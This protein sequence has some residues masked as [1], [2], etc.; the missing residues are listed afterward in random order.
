MSAPADLDEL[1]RRVD[2][3][4]ADGDSRAALAAALLRAGEREAAAE[5]WYLAACSAR[6]DLP[7]LHERLRRVLE[8]EPAYPLVFTAPPLAHP[9][10]REPWARLLVVIPESRVRSPIA[11]LLAERGYEVVETPTAGSARAAIRERAFDLVLTAPQT[12]DGDAL[13]VAATARKANPKTAIVLL[14]C[15]AKHERIDD[16]LKLQPLVDE[17]LDRPLAAERLTD[18]VKAALWRHRHATQVELGPAAAPASSPPSLLTAWPRAVLLVIAGYAVIF[19]AD[20][21]LRTLARARQSESGMAAGLSGPATAPLPDELD[22]A[23][24]RS[25]WVKLTSQTGGATATLSVT[26]LSPE[27]VAARTYRSARSG[28]PRRAPLPDEVRSAVERFCGP[29][30]V[31][32]EAQLALKQPLDLDPLALAR[33]VRLRVADRPPLAP[34]L[35][36][37]LKEMRFVRE[38]APGDGPAR[39][40][41]LTF[42]VTF[43]EALLGEAQVATLEL[44][45]A[46]ETLI[47]FIPIEPR[48]RR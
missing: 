30:V 18:A 34:S 2:R 9:G 48:S 22:W 13:G 29:G 32:F 10:E 12:A 41:A 46:A 36:S 26:T 8:A 3:D 11:R 21:L 6:T 35:T 38:T 20:G 27:L 17:H 31:S 43:Q 14:T 16:A 37:T 28:A 45:L 4:P 15:A 24:E 19:A 1:R 33:A 47:V 39:L 5:A 44:P 25:L 42:A 40:S 23:G 7:V